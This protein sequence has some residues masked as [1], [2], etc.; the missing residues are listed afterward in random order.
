M[1]WTWMRISDAHKS[2]DSEIVLN[3]KGSGWNADF[4]QKETTRRCVTP[5]PQQ[6]VEKLN[7]SPGEVK[8][9]KKHFF[10]CTYTALR[11]RVDTLAERA[12]KDQPC[13]TR[14]AHIAVGAPSPSSTSTWARM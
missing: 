11:M 6:V 7:T 14:S 1:R 3:E 4:I 2:N 8:D 13:E 5:I 12:Q 10:T 9:G